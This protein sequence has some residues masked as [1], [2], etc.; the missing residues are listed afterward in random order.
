MW[1][2]Q[3]RRVFQFVSPDGQ[4]LFADPIAVHRLLGIHTGGRLAHFVN[5]VRV[6]NPPAEGEEDRRPP[7]DSPEWVQAQQ[8]WGVLAQATIAAFGLPPF[9]AMTGTGTLEAEA[10]EL[11]VRF[12]AWTTEKKSN[13]ST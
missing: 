3:D 10:Q 13:P 5:L 9:D 11:F 1:Q 8:A 12:W 7:Q 4:V 2:E 6:M